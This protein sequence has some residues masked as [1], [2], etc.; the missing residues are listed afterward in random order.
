MRIMTMAAAL[1][2]L[3]LPLSAQDKAAPKQGD[4]K[5]EY[6]ALADDFDQTMQKW[7]QEAQ[8]QAAEAEKNGGRVPPAPALEPLVK[9]LISRA[10]GLAEKYK[11]KDDA[12][13]FLVFVTVNASGDNQVR[14]AFTTLLADHVK[15]PQ[16]AGF[17]QNLPRTAHRAGADPVA[18]LGKI[19]DKNK[20]KPVLAVALLT[21]GQLRLEN[22]S[23]D[24][25]RAIV[26]KDLEQVATLEAPAEVKQQAASALFQLEHLGIG[27][28]APEIEGK[29]M[30]GTAF[31]LSDYR[32]KVVLLDFWGFW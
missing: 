14:K 30:D 7:R 26:K 32:G 24:A 11:G 28:A 5:T 2:L 19:L 31:K 27:C 22:A 12:V 25:E 17:V 20:S 4:A 10:Q 16:L 13:Q 6:Q 29:D 9:D 3:P 15:S 23:S 1:L 21:R 8:Q 18:V